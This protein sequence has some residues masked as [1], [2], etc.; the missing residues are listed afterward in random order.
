MKRIILLTV[1]CVYMM[2]ATVFAAPFASNSNG[3]S[4]MVGE[5][6][7]YGQ[8]DLSQF[9]D[10]LQI[11]ISEKLQDSDNFHVVSGT[12]DNDLMKQIHMNAIVRGHLY[13]KGVSG[14]ELIKYANSVLGKSYRPTDAEIEAKKKLTGTPYSLSPDVA[15]A[16]KAYGEREGVDYL[17][18]A[19]L[20]YVEVWLRNSI[21]SPNVPKEYRGKAVSTNV[22]FYLVNTKTGK[23][24]DGIGS[25]KTTAQQINAW[26]VNF[27]KAMDMGMIA[28]GIMDKHVKHISKK[29][30]SDGMKAL[31]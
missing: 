27:G 25:E 20:N 14:P 30:S 2:C 26:I 7:C 6:Y 5:V 15:D 31:K 16:A 18:F 17:V 23:V 19:N 22:E 9:V 21:F 1:L 11:A 10:R 8:Y 28:S 29:I 24:Y 3:P 12:P 4:V 13:D